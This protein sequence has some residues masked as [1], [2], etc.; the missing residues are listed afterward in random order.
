TKI[1]TVMVDPS[2]QVPVVVLE[3]V[4]DQRALPIWIDVAEAR[5][6]ALELEHVRT[7]RPLTH[8]LMRN[9]LNR[10]GATLERVV[11]TD[12]RDNT[13]F[14]LL[15]LRLKGQ[16]LQIDARPSDAIALALRMK[17]PIFASAQV[18]A[19]ST[20]KP[21]PT[22][23][24]EGQRKLGIQAQDLTTE[25]ATLLDVRLDSGVV[26]ADVDL[27]GPAAAVG[28][29][30][31]DIITKANNT[32]IKTRADFER[33]IR[34]LKSPAQIKLEITKKGKSTIVVIDLPS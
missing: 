2:S 31:G 13:Y 4:S 20:M 21:N 28:I 9:I 29:Q 17:A 8:D 30:R 24:H 33:M 26:V 22:R 16:E 34:S 14:A 7:P 27:G 11:I 6:I 23:A 25:L 15:Y 12:L 18:L 5:A 10:L 1:K 32:P 19:T 3:S